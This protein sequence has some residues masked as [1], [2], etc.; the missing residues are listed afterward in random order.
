M[1]YLVAGVVALLL[2]LG[3]HVRAE[4]PGIAVVVN[5][6]RL[7]LDVAPVIVEGRTLVPLRAIFEALGAVVSYDPDTRTITATRAGV[8][9]VITVGE[10]RALVGGREVALDVPARI[11]SGRTLVPV[12]FVAE[13]FGAR[14]LWDGATRTVTVNLDPAAGPAGGTPSGALPPVPYPT[15]WSAAMQ[16]GC[17]D[18]EPVRFGSPPLRL[19]DIVGVGPYGIIAGA[20]VIPTDHQGYMFPEMG[21]T[22]RYDVL[23]VGDGE[24]VQVT[25]RTVSVDTGRPSSPQYHVTLR[26][27]CSIITQYDLIDEL[28]PALAA[29]AEDL[30]GGR[31]IPIRAGEVIG[32]TGASSQGLD[33]WVADL[34]TLVPDLV[35]PQHYEREPWRL[36]VIDPFSLFSEPLRSQLLAK[37]MRLAEPRGGR[38]NYDSDGRLVGGWFVANTNGYAGLSP[39]RFWATHLAVVYNAYDPTLVIVSLADFEGRPRQFAVKGNAPDPAQVSVA[40]GPVK[41]E[42]MYYDYE[43]AVSGVKWDYQAPVH[44]LRGVP[45]GEV[46]G[47]VLMQLIAD[48]RLKVEVFPGKRADAVSGFTA[49]AVIYER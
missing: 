47:T 7:N 8:T 10:G 20:H 17:Q 36:Y 37:S 9:V 28:A 5:G 49:A 23:A 18:R 27:S 44:Q 22:P 46:R 30:R 48:R 12:R 29:Q 33:F 25:V 40:T 16:A 45:F 11:V 34:R 1:R 26:H 42:L 35:V 43:D 32:K 3:P 24:I 14:V 41:Y 13:S 31:T 6:Q 19:A 4:D 39:D 38:A 2:L 15:W 21:T